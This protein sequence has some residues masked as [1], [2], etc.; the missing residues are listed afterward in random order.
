[1]DWV[2]LLNEYGFPATLFL[3]LASHAK[4]ILTFVER[5]LSKIWPSFAE[6]RRLK[7]KRAMAADERAAEQQRLKQE[8]IA[9]AKREID[10]VLALKEM[11]LAYRQRLDD[12]NL[13]RRQ[14]ENR[15]YE[16]VGLYHRRDAQMIEALRDVSE[17]L[18]SQTRRL[19][20][21]TTMMRIQN[22]EKKTSHDTE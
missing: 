7:L 13:E 15:I 10:T 8:S 20:E 19:D 9:A 2:K 11:L 6:Q 1:M 18:R 14:Q 4:S 12:L 3:L 22:G 5:L 21:I 17:V 16:L